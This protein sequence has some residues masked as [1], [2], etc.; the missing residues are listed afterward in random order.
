M[1]SVVH[2]SAVVLPA[3]IGSIEP[4]DTTTELLTAYIVGWE[5]LIRL[6]L[7][8]P[9]GYQSRGF[10]TAAV[11]G[12]LG[13]AATSSRL[14]KRDDVATRNAMAISTSFAGGLMAYAADGANIKRIHL[15]WAAQS[16]IA[17][18]TLSDWGVDGATEALE[19]TYGFVKSFTGLDVD[20]GVLESLGSVWEMNNVA[21]KLYP[22]C[23]FIH[24]YID[25]ALELRQRLNVNSIGKL[26][27][28][29][30]P[31]AIPVIGS[32]ELGVI[33]ARNLSSVQYNLRLCVAL[34]ACRGSVSLEGLESIDGDEEVLKFASKIEI[35]A[36][37]WMEYPGSFGGFLRCYDE[38]GVCLDEV[39]RKSPS[40]TDLSEGDL[41]AAVMA[42]FHKNAQGILDDDD[43][44]DIITHLFDPGEF[45]AMEWL[46]LL[47]KEA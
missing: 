34:A 17:A 41:E 43:Q 28:Y 32:S 3:A 31:N 42:K 8:A 15:G 44:R 40:A 27:C 39:E 11:C 33:E 46:T 35:V 24:A 14:K 21:F 2:G 5:F 7:L 1:S 12:P 16:G 18:A 23:H 20:Y 29:V 45:R 26:E 6:G 36:A 22:C 25:C 13:A 19:G 10:Q 38:H 4:D 37:P 9:G 47:T 30:H